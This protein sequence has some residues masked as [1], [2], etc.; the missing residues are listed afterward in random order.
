LGLRD[1]TF[2][3]AASALLLAGA[4]GFGGASGLTSALAADPGTVTLR[5][6]L[7]DGTGHALAGVALEIREELAAGGGAASW[8]LTTDPDGAFAAEVFAWGTTDGPARVTIATAPGTEIEIAD[9]SCS[10]TW[11][12]GVDT[13]LELALAEA[14][15]DP[16]TVTATTAL[17]GEV[18]GTTGTPGNGSGSDSGAA[19][20]DSAVGDGHTAAGG[21][22]VTPP[23]TDVG[24]LP[25]E[26]H[27]DRR[28]SALTIGF[29]LGLAIAAI[30]LQPGR[31]QR[32][33]S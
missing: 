9:D 30:V 17:V 15:P 7:V 5:G 27:A 4:A 10:R 28:G 33:R 3:A 11:S 26:G 6:T 25:V 32:R 18:C 21:R 19:G 31:G 23:P 1:R 8:P 14:A 12:V 2:R 29:V 24:P 22:G 13:K 20:S 16:L